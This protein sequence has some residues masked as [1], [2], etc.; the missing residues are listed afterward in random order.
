MVYVF[1]VVVVT[2]Y[3]GV[4]FTGFGVSIGPAAFFGVLLSSRWPSPSS[5]RCPCLETRRA[6]RPQ[7]RR[8]TP[9]SSSTR[10]SPSSSSPRPPTSGRSS[11]CSRTPGSGSPACPRTRRSS[12][13]P[14]NATPGAASRNL[15][16]RAE[17]H[18]H[19][20]RGARRPPVRRRLD[21]PL[22]RRLG[23]GGSTAAFGLATVIG[24][25][26][27]AY[28]AAFGREFEAYA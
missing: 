14:P 18:R 28:F 2:R 21:A 8:G 27:V 9:D 22:R 26:G 19:P 16:P 24:L 12:S 20:E 1:F 3:L 7:T 4:G 15:L 17:H 25:V 11:R 23:D 5:R 13:G 10:R 6:N